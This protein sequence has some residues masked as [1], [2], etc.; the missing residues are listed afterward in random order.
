MSKSYSTDLIFV[1]GVAATTVITLQPRRRTTIFSTSNGQ[2]ESLGLPSSISEGFEFALH[3]QQRFVQ[4]ASVCF[5]F[6]GLYVQLLKIACF[7]F[8]RLGLGLCSWPDQSQQDSLLQE[9]QSTA[10]SSTSSLHFRNF[11]VTLQWS[12]LRL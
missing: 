4:I 5:F 9:C 2:M 8:A 10:I 6:P 1:V 11:T 7:A 3:S 12:K